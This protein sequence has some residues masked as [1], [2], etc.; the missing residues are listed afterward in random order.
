MIGSLNALT[1]RQ[2]ADPMVGWDRTHDALSTRMAKGWRSR[3]GVDRKP[4][5]MDICAHS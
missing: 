3:E 2:V 5:G 4:S 1:S